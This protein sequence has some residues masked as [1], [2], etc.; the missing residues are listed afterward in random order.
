MTLEEAK[1][2]KP[3][4]YVSAVFKVEMSF[5]EIFDSAGNI[6]LRAVNEKGD[7][8]FY[9]SLISPEFVKKSKKPRRKFLTGDIVMGKDGEVRVVFEDECDGRV[10]ISDN[11]FD[12]CME[13]DKP[14]NFTLICAAEDRRDRKEEA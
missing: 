12:S 11:E 7:S 1:Q 13:Y 14:R 9:M 8:N 10:Y 6:K 2:L 4:E 5:G 3:G